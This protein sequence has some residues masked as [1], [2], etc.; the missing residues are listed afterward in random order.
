M[1]VVCNLASIN[2]PKLVNGNKFDFEKLCNI[3][4]HITRCLNRVIDVNYYPVPEAEYSNK[5]NRPIGIG[6]QGLADVFAMLG[7]PFDSKEAIEMD[8]MVFETIYFGA[9]SESVELAAVH[10]PY[11]SYEGS[12]ISKGL[13]QFDLWGVKPQLEQTWDSLR[14]KVLKYGVRNSLVTAPMPTGSTSLILD[15][16]ACFEPFTGVIFQ[17]ETLSGSYTR[18]N[19]NLVKQLVDLGLWNTKVSSQDIDAHHG[20]IQRIEEIPKEIRKLYKIVWEIKQK[21]VI[22]HAIARGPFI[23]QSQSMNLYF[24]KIVPSKISSALFYAWEN[25]LKTGL[26]YVR[27]LPETSAIQFTIGKEKKQ[28]RNYSSVFED[29]C[30]SCSA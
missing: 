5:K 9:M 6:V 2:L 20:S 4:S 14:E 19:K 13:F 1:H 8:S 24:E 29:E 12:P 22:D 7:L 17:Q 16:T 15:N 27:Q 26:Y 11:E 28:Q 25:G 10:G 21:S 18:V 23:D 3:A 30:T